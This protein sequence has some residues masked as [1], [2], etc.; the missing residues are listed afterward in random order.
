MHQAR[1]SAFF[2]MGYCK[3]ARGSE[4]MRKANSRLSSK[5]VWVDKIFA[6]V[7]KKR[8][9]VATLCRDENCAMTSRGNLFKR[10]R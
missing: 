5:K 1:L 9:L 2:I 3:D 7:M 10:H 4:G 6:V 8:S